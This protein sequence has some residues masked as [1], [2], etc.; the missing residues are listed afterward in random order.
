MLALSSK[1]PDLILPFSYAPSP[2]ASL[3]TPCTHTV[4]FRAT[5]KLGHTSI[6]SRGSQILS[7]CHLGFGVSRPGTMRACTP[8]SCAT[9]VSGKAPLKVSVPHSRPWPKRPPKYPPGH[10]PL[11]PLKASRLALLPQPHA[12]AAGGHC[13]SRPSPRRAHPHSLRFLHHPLGRSRRDQ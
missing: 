11:F 13:P 5:S 4:D 9:H 8:P 7:P 2:D 12:C 3:P 6:P 10:H 1:I